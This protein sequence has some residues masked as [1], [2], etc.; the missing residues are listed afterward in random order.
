M[1][2]RKK[3]SEIHLDITADKRQKLETYYCT[4]EDGIAMIGGKYKK[5]I[6]Y[7][8]MK[9]ALRYNQIYKARQNDTL[10]MI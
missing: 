4:M 8:C 3:D 7:H 9:G 2:K 10:K 1:A 5:M 6:I